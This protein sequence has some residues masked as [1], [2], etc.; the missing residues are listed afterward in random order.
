MSA[1]QK[2]LVLSLSCLFLVYALPLRVDSQEQAKDASVLGSGHGID[3]VGIAVR[4]LESA[5]NTYRQVLGFSVFAFGKESHGVRS[6][7]SYLESGLLELVTPWD[8]TQPIG[9]VVATFLEKHEGAM[10]LGLDV[11]PVDET[12]KFLRTRGFNF[13]GPETGSMR[14]DSDQHDYARLEGSWR[15]GGFESGPVPAAHI[16]TRSTDAIFFIQYDPLA[17]TVHPNTAKKLSSVWMAVR[18]LEATVK[19][20][21]SMGFRSGRKLAAPQLGAK[22]QEIEAGDGIILLL[23]S[24]QPTGKVA[25]FLAERGAEG[26]MGV[27]IEVASLQTARSLLE[28]NTKENSNH[29]LDHT[30]RACLSHLNL[31]TV[32][33][34]NFS[35]SDPN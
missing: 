25:S 11:S 7:G 3:H 20:Y 13:Q 19:E 28:A 5:K 4:D 26:I 8:R 14:E 24:H 17:A 16:P 35:K 15:L 32:S 33:G 34:L 31:H 2:H 23:Q 27:S 30:E 12:V 22:S 9:A 6:G 1:A 29:T 10:Y 18:D 21:E